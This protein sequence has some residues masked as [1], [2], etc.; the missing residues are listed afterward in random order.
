MLV[1]D[2]VDQFEQF[3]FTF[4]KLSHNIKWKHKDYNL[5][6]ELDALL[7]NGKQAM[8]V[9]VKAKLDKADVMPICTGIPGNFLRDGRPRQGG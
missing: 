3:G 5:A 2:L 7:E 9:E 8:V 1:P 4:E 6:M